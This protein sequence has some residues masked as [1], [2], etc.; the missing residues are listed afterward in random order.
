[1]FINEV[2]CKSILNKSGILGIDYAIN[3][4]Y[5]CSHKCQYCYAVFM[6]KFTGH[7]EPWGE[8]VDVKVNA[9]EVLARQIR[10]LKTRSRI[11]FGTVC[12]P[13]QPLELKYQV[14]RKC[15]EILAPSRHRVSI[16]TKSAIIVRDA[17]ILRTMHKIRVSF[18]VTT[19]DERVRSVFEPA[20][21]PAEKRFNALRTIAQN[22]IRTSVFV[23]PVLPYISDS[24]SAIAGLFRAAKTA[25]A[26]Y[27]MFDTLNP[28]PKVWY[29][30]VRL[31]K[32]N[33][34]EKLGS[35]SSYYTNQK[36]YQVRLREK[37]SRLADECAMECKFA[38]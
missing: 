33:F 12:D 32:K 16:L 36:M 24:S 13:Y 3:P 8:F 15:L 6:K 37:I 4:Y 20:A 22:G 9:P 7:T 34:P 27:V 2:K 19:L 21:P 11:S 10:R 5:G 26:E 23:A 14:T 28:Y 25:G 1:M 35:F 18:T 38:F 29:N 31:V 30:T 17:G